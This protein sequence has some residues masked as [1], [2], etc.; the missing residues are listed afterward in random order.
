MASAIEVSIV[1]FQTS[2]TTAYGSGS[3]PSWLQALL[4]ALEAALPGILA[5]CGV[6]ATPD[7]IKTAIADNP[8]GMRIKFLGVARDAGV[9]LRE[10]TKAA[11]ALETTVINAAAADIT[12]WLAF[13]QAS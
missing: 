10:R 9:P 1:N 8:V 5:G 13:A 11:V 3:A 7:A 4:A 12:N 6:A 2:F